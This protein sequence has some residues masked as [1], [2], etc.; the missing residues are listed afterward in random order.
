MARKDKMT[1]TSTTNAA[2]N[3]RRPTLS[4]QIDRLDATLD[5][6]AEGLNE[7]VADAVQSAVGTA[8]REAVQ[9]TLAE[10]LANP[11]AL[12][13]LRA[14]TMPPTQA[15]R[16]PEPKRP[17]LW[18]RLGQQWQR[19]RGC[20]AG[21][22]ETGGAGLRRVASWLGGLWRC[23]A[24]GGVS[25]W[26]RCRSLAQFRYELLTAFGVGT[27]AA[28]AA[29]FAGPWLSALLGGV[30]GFATTAAVWGWLGLRRALA[31]GAEQ[32]A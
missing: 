21:L 18:E 10:V 22:R 25:L 27:A 17:G 9:V 3:S 1:M 4:E 20:L 13:C 32:A 28:V 5:G 16:P 14:T 24:R 6:L 15:A 11:D 31:L 26:S 19:V 23:V 29:W 2:I 30:G 8:V 7:A 12:A